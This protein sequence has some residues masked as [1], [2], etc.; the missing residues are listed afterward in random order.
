VG[1]NFVPVAA[2]LS[3]FHRDFLIVFPLG[4]RTAL[5][6][7]PGKLSMGNYNSGESDP[8]ANSRPYPN[9]G[10]IYNDE[11]WSQIYP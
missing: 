11:G 6:Q 5:F 1:I 4:S 10:E 8:G 2:T 3:S 7:N 9:G